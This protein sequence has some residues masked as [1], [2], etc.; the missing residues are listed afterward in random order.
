MDGLVGPWRLTEWIAERGDAREH[1]FGLAAE[2]RLI[3][4]PAGVMAAFLLHPEWASLP[5]D[6]VPQRQRFI[7]YSGRYRLEGDEVVH[8]VDASSDPRWI[9]RA[10]RRRMAW[11]DDKLV[12]TAE[13]ASSY[14]IGALRH[15]LSWIRDTGRIGS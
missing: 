5:V 13:P 6:H 10:L 9:G 12:L 11:E 4:D 3:Y 1:P 15:R 7:S 8:D 2:G 14:G